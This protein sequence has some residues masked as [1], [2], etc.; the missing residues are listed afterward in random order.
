MLMVC[1]FFRRLVMSYT[2][3]DNVF[4]TIAQKMPHLFIA[5]IN[6]VF[7]TEFPDDVKFEQLRNE[8]IEENGKIITDSIFKIKGHIFHIECQS[9]PDGEMAIRMI[10]YDFAIAFNQAELKGAPYRVE[11][12]ESCVLYLRHNSKTPNELNVEVSFRGNSI[13]YTTKVIK[14]QNYTKDEIFQKRLLLL[15]PFYILRYES[16]IKASSD[17]VVIEQ[18]LTDYRDIVNRMTKNMS[19][20]EFADLAKLT[21]R[22]IEHISPDNNDTLKEVSKVMGGEVLE[23]ESERCIRI[24]REELAQAIIDI[25]N[26]MSKEELAEKYDKE[27]LDLAYS[28]I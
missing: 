28:C 13:P 25:K 15:I 26:N 18:I 11:L 23:L 12:P 6:E 20:T 16:M 9:T 4:R 8:F 17:S 1:L 5:L 21:I 27:T 14:A 10:E 24:G 19:P 3:F 22:I 2:E 7:H